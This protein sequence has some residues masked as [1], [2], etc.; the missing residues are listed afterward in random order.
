MKPPAELP[1]PP[2]RTVEAVRSVRESVGL[3]P[4]AN[5]LRPYSINA[6]SLLPFHS[7]PCP[8]RMTPHHS[9]AAAP[10]CHPPPPTQ[11]HP[12]RAKSWQ[13]RMADTEARTARAVRRLQSTVGLGVGLVTAGLAM[14]LACTQGDILDPVL[15]GS[16][17]GPSHCP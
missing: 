13:P 11:Y 3:Q 1:Q 17:S 6:I 9:R 7:V 16:L 15:L 8:R 12:A 14:Q 2:S 4:A 5:E 10:L